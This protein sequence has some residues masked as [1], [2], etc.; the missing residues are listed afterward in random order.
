[1][2]NSIRKTTLEAVDS[3]CVDSMTMQYNITKISNGIIG[4]QIIVVQIIVYLQY[5]QIVVNVQQL[6]FK[7]ESSKFSMAWVRQSRDGSGICQ[8]V[9]CIYF[10]GFN[11]TLGSLVT[12]YE[13]PKDL[14]K[15]YNSNSLW[16]RKHGQSPADKR[17]LK[18]LG[19]YA[20]IF[21]SLLQQLGCYQEPILFGLSSPEWRIYP[22]TNFHHSQGKW[23]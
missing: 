5:R 12:K 23:L 2:V 17:L 9:L 20:N 21:M 16:L 11:C 18:F 8:E 15:S 1:M 13:K 7:T 3:I 14:S 19:S 22:G 10:T 6:W 4:T